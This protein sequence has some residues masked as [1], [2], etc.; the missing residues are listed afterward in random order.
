MKPE[1]GKRLAMIFTLLLILNLP[2]IHALQIA[3]VRTEEITE[4][5]ALIK[6]ET[7]E[8]ADSFVSY[9]LD[10]DT[11]TKVGDANPI[12]N[13]QFSLTGL[14]ASTAY[15]YKVESNNVLEDNAGN[16]Y[17][18]TTLAP[19][20]TAPELQVEFP[21]LVQ[22]NKLTISGTTEI[23][24]GVELFI[25]GGLVKSTTALVNGTVGIFT[26]VEALLKSDEPNAVEVRA[27]DAKG[28]SVSA[29]GVV[30]SDTKKPLITL[31]EIPT[32]MSEATFNFNGSV[33]ENS[34]IEIFQDE[35]LIVKM[36]GTSF[37]QQVQLQEGKN[38]LKIVAKDAAGWEASE[39]VEVTA[40][41]AVPMVKF[42]L[43]SGYEYYEGRAETDITGETE[44]G[45]TVFLYV[46]QQGVSEY[47]PDF[48]RA[49]ATATADEQG[50]F[51]FTDVSFPPS[52]LSRLER[53]GPREVPAGLQDILISPLDKIAQE[54][55]KSFR[56]IIIAEDQT[57]KSGHLER[58]VNVNSCY[59]ANFGFDVSPHP[60]FPPT[61]FRLDPGS[62]EEGREQIQAIFE[63]RYRGDAQERV[64]PS[65]G[66]L[67]KGYRVN[68]VFFEKACSKEQAEKGDFKLGCQLLPPQFKVQSNAPEN[69]IHYLTAQLNRAADFTKREENPWDDFVDKRQ[70]KMP[71]K[72]RINYQERDQVGNF[73]EQKTQVFC[74]DL[75]YFVDVPIDSSELV[76]DFLAEEGVK[77]LNWTI[78]QIEAV[79]PY[80]ETVT[81][82]AGVGCFGSWGLKQIA[83]LYRIFIS[84]YE[85]WWTKFKPD[86]K[87]EGCPY[88]KDGQYALY[89]EETIK[90]WRD[91][92]KGR[93]IPKGSE[94]PPWLGNPD[95][96][97]KNSLTERC[98]QTAAAWK[99]EEAIDKGYRFSC[100]RFL[101]R[102]VPAGWTATKDKKEVDKV[103][104]E[105][106]K[107]AASANCAYLQ[108][109]E[110]CE[111]VFEENPTAKQYLPK[112]VA[113]NSFYCYQNPLTGLH[114]LEEDNEDLR[115][116]GITPLK[117]VRLNPS[118][119]VGKDIQLFAYKQPGSSQLCIG[120]DVLC[121]TQCRKKEG[122]KAA[123]S[124][125]KLNEGKGGCYKEVKKEGGK[126]ELQ[127][128]S[129]NP[130][131]ETQ[132][133]L[134][135][136]YTKDCFVNKNNP[137][138]GLY[139]CV[140][141]QKKVGDGPNQDK[142][143]RQALKTENNVAEPWFYHQ[144]RVYAL[145][146]GTAGTYYPPWRYY[147]GRDWSG[148]FGQ[149]WAFDNFKEDKF[150]ETQVNPH[151][152]MLGT[153]QSLCLRGIL[154]R[155]NQL[156]GTLV[157][158]RDCIIQAEHTGLQDAGLCKAIFTQ[159]VCGLIYK[160]I[161]YLGSGCSP[162]SFKDLVKSKDYSV[163]G[164]GAFFDAGFKAIPGAMEESIQE[165]KSDYG[166]ANVRQ[167]F[168]T[169]AQ[170]FAESL[171]LAAFGYDFPMGMD[172]IQDT[173]L[174]FS[175]AV[176]PM[177]PIAEREL[178]SFDPVKG[179]TVYNYHVG[180][181]LWP[182][183][184]LR[185]YTVSLKCVGPEDIAHPD[186]DKS[187]LGKGCDCLQA[188][189]LSANSAVERTKQLEQGGSDFR[190]IAKGSL[191]SLPI[192][193]PQKVS[194]RYRY[195]HIKFEVFLDQFENP[196][197]CIDKGRRTP[198][199]GV[200]YYP[201]RDI[202]PE[203]AIS[204]F[205]DPVSG[206]F[207]CPAV[208]QLFSQGRTYFEHPFVQCYDKRKDDFFDC[209][210]ANVLLKE[211]EIVIKPH[212]QLGGSGE[213][214]CLR[215]S[216][217]SNRINMQTILLPENQQGQYTP[218]LLLGTVTPQMIS[219]GGVGTIISSPAND[220][221][222]WRAAPKSPSS[223]A[224]KPVAVEFKYYP[225]ADGK[226]ILEIPSAVSVVKQNGYD[227]GVNRALVKNNQQLTVEEISAAEFIV[228]GFTFNLVE[229]RPT[230]KVS[231][232]TYGTCLYNTNP[233]VLTATANFGMINLQLELLKPGPNED[234]W[235]TRTI[236]PLT[237]LGK[238]IV[239]QPLRLQLQL[240]EQAA[241]SSLHA[242]FRQG[243]YHNVQLDANMIIAQNQPTLEDAVAIYYYLASIIAQNNGVPTQTSQIQAL[244]STFFTREYEPQTV[245]S[246]TEYQKIKVYLCEI[247]PKANYTPPSGKCS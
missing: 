172:F 168:A 51:T 225:Q 239:S 146:Q 196:E 142:G 184:K 234:C 125:I 204:C 83:K 47:R 34:T 157:G 57:G 62:M 91:E 139:Q 158:I 188:S 135:A 13:H 79:K 211:E 120:Y 74:Y 17:S 246:K 78:T 105:Q 80:L 110:N 39:E 25:N 103:I 208:Q 226:Y 68:T 153:F 203:V 186:V 128:K 247:A 170:G 95:E 163:E 114:Y 169:G 109:I 220:P 183:C 52:L 76:P 216:D 205:V 134:S 108:K 113:G 237:S 73:G 129:N 107:C 46:F 67:E 227:I 231:G 99:F 101:C 22:G 174:S 88:P 1:Q 82:F 180:G 84:E 45:A 36:Q 41:T 18:F 130:L 20:V 144:D 77:S 14:A 238:N 159:Y 148:A 223:T 11:L 50:K 111:K 136:G 60:Q 9:G 7:D 222:C 182:G 190:G 154:A 156:E 235:N 179:N 165:I 93:T 8:P 151:T 53:A 221:G 137:D 27:T 236:M 38:A 233:G 70:L 75:G 176:T 206:Q 124:G 245:T 131:E 218:R 29:S 217:P 102:P 177:F 133:L 162:L 121:D 167:F 86:N 191:T 56:V 166:D 106:K 64:N 173:A 31:P 229:G 65:T 119:A 71:L 200:F 44:P 48:G 164:I 232:A 35:K 28:N 147:A 230:P 66:Q 98:P 32:L 197:N 198:T 72:I 6:W 241:V 97:K 244:L 85:P 10:K 193:T 19:D 149:R 132:D 33:S 24:A 138:E 23:N 242:K 30:I 90:Q 243:D 81:I 55:R 54:Q 210:N 224:G 240:Q 214:A 126:I 212:L 152:Q 194:S 12:L 112:E 69:T 140:C 104:L 3:N 215:I 187:C 49:I 185:G 209:Q 89:T 116:L 219:G 202:T 161:A 145:S 37:S 160:G 58:V 5:S 178:A 213:R 16:L 228:E 40:D 26:F 94:L 201:I 43:V 141:E 100:D 15:V 127:D 96:E 195:D 61:P 122:F 115:A 118:E 155:V 181:T 192:P 175:T 87:D 171:C 150:A 63:M 117:Y 199:G 207:T 21:A 2:F 143:S 59:S 42:E 92:L 123:E 4:N 189:G